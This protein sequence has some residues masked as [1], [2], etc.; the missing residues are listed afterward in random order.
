MKIVDAITDCT[1]PP[2]IE[3]CF[4]RTVA[5]NVVEAADAHVERL[6]AN[7]FTAHTWF[8][9][10]AGPAVLTE[11]GIAK[12]LRNVAVPGAAF[13]GPCVRRQTAPPEF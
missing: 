12:T 9:L 11:S 3:G 8:A 4:Q 5:P 2:M 10:G 7:I 13:G 6:F 1:V